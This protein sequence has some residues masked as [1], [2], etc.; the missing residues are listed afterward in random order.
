MTFFSR[1]V[2]GTKQCVTSEAVLAEAE[3]SHEY[4]RLVIG[5]SHL[6]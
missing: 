4:Q 3:G 2:A 5:S 1:T 6:S